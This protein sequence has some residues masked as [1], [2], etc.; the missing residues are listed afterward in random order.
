MK[1]S[2]RNNRYKSA[3]NNKLRINGK[4][5][6]KKS[7]SVITKQD[8]IKHLLQCLE[9]GN[10]NPVRNYLKSLLPRKVY[11]PKK[12]NMELGFVESRRQE[13]IA[14]QT[15]AESFAKIILKEMDIKFTFQQDFVCK[16]GK[17]YYIDF[18]FPLIKVGIEI[19]GGY[20]FTDE[21]MAN[22]EERQK[23][24]E[25]NGVDIYRFTNYKVLKTPDKFREGIREIIKK[26]KT[27]II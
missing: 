22:D 2:K 18:Y 21:Q 1:V 26:Y 10:L 13:L 5:L 6:K 25:S 17:L 12:N 16:N 11:I 15:R 19:D 14:K 20:H 8:N 24:I 27:E 7:D 9:E 3:R 4:L 23:N